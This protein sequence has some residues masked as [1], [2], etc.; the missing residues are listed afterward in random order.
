ALRYVSSDKGLEATVEKMLQGIR[1]PIGKEIVVTVVPLQPG[2]KIKT[3]P[4]VN[5]LPNLYE[6]IPFVVYGTIDS[7]KD[8]HIFF[9]G[10]YYDK[11]LDI[12]QKVSFA[13]ASTV[14]GA[15][16]ERNFAVQR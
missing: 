6:N 16:L 5:L 3:Y 1:N 13:Q 8:F 2:A 12:K 9:Q 4:P 11:S 10:K 7:L 15:E 14:D